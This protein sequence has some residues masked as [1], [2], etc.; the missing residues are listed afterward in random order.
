MAVWHLSSVTF[1]HS[2]L[3]S[4]TSS[5]FLYNGILAC[6]FKRIHRDIRILETVHGN[7]RQR[8]L[9]L[10]REKNMAFTEFFLFYITFYLVD[11]CGHSGRHRKHQEIR[12]EQDEISVFVIVSDGDRSHVDDVAQGVD[13]ISLPIS[14]RASQNFQFQFLLAANFSALRLK[15]KIYYSFDTPWL[16]SGSTGTVFIN[17]KKI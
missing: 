16:L 8:K 6:N 12:G 5:C 1:F 17:C 10:R 14:N 7:S 2:F 11:E 13:A 9:S 15:W 4:S 3:L